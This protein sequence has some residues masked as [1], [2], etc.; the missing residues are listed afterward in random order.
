MSRSTLRL[1]L[2]ALAVLLVSLP[3]AGCK[4]PPKL[5]LDGPIHG[6]ITSAS[7]IVAAG[8]LTNG[9]SGAV[10]SVNGISVPVAPDGTWSTSVP[11]DAVAIVNPIVAEFTRPS[12]KVLR[13]RVTVLVGDS[14]ADGGYSPMGVALRLNDAGL[15][16]VEPIVSSLVDLDLAT[17]LPVGTTVINNYC[18]VDGGFL[19]C[20]GEVDVKV[21]SPTPSFS[22]FG[23]DVDSMTGF[24]AGDVTVNDIRVDL[25]IDGSGLAPSCG[26]RITSS[27][28]S[29]YG[30][31]GLS[32]AAVD[33]TLVDVN[34]IGA[35]A[36]S[37]TNFNDQFTSGLCDFP[38]IGD[39]IQLIIGDIR[40]VV[41][42]GLRDFL[43][44]PDGSGPL[45][46]P[47]AE[48]IETA[49][50]DIQIA[51]A[52]GESI[53]VGID[54]PLF[55][56]F[57]DEVGLTLDSDAAITASAPDPE[58]PDLL[59]SWHTDDVFPDFAVCEGGSSAGLACSGNP[60]CPS[61]TCVSRTPSGLDYH[62]GISIS[63]S[64]FNQLMKSEVESGLL[65]TVLTE[66]PFGG[67]PAP[68]TGAF[69]ALLVPE[70]QDVDPAATFEIRIA[71]TMAP[72]LSGEPGPTGE[73]ADL[74]IPHLQVEVVE[75][76][77]GEV[78]LAF[79][80]DARVGLDLGFA[81]GELAIT[82][83]G[84][85]TEELGLTIL[86]NLLGT[87]EA[88]LQALLL[89]IVPPLFPSLAG[90]LGSF[91]LPGFL[92]LELSYVDVGHQGQ[93]L[94]LYFDLAQAP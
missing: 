70:F 53:G 63:T 1:L 55:D 43:A 15:D 5:F 4:K 87:D 86:Q 45:D 8:R 92:G 77:T 29:I 14:I 10:V 74:R 19:G 75:Q 59:G 82:I 17:L 76:S 25:D 71:P 33:P 9:P 46:A 12:G 88:S 78:F 64:A 48:G 67:N 37:F 2:A 40:P 47:I 22:G 34:L 94:T 30:D 42:N 58:A 31:Y 35:P 89:A 18:A 28:V 81:N 79:A 11:L 52:I 85:Q 21:A 36:V 50:A 51:G 93:Y 90:S 26:L 27:Q 72:F 91:P 65:R 20:L 16:E 41:T 6:T 56:V 32:P 84:L 49:L 80:V 83:A 69:L 3:I 62:M 23:L 66:L 57:E 61:G 39:L 73:L 68:L 7:S 13:K 44:D 38:L 54:A 24:A 60:D